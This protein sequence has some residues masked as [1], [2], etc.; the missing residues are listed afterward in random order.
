MNNLTQS[1]SR[2]QKWCLLTLVTLVGGALLAVGASTVIATGQGADFADVFNEPAR[3]AEGLVDVTWSDG[4]QLLRSLE[5]QTIEGIEFAWTRAQSSIARAAV[6]GDTTGVDVWFSGPAQDQ[7]HDLV[8]TGAV[9]D[10]GAW[11]GHEITPEFY[12]I[13]G[14]ILVVDIERVRGEIDGSIDGTSVSSDEVRAVFVLRDGNWRVEHLVRTV[15][16]S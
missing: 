16:T 7:V 10:A 12:S 11:V 1:L 15:A 9:L 13:D 3:T 4:P 2:L 6:D 14:Q 8:A 5:P